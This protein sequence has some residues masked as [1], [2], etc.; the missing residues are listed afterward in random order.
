MKYFFKILQCSPYSR[1]FIRPMLVTSTLENTLSTHVMGSPINNTF[2]VAM[3]I[4]I[5][6]QR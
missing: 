5:W 1:L 3:A 2:P 6:Q 4:S